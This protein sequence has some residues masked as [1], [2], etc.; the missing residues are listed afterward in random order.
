MQ[1][2]HKYDISLLHGAETTAIL[3]S[4]S[5][6]RTA[7]HSKPLVQDICMLDEGGPRCY[8]SC[9]AASILYNI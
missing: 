6:N 4:S 1:D 9:T 8:A 2:G 7:E 5:S 3:S